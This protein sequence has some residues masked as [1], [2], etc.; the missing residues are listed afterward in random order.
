M[1]MESIE[2]AVKEHLKDQPYEV[3]CNSC[4][5]SVEHE[6]EVDRDGDLIVEVGICECVKV[7]RAE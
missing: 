3:K 4:G 5:A 6:T 1:S 7:G 2:K